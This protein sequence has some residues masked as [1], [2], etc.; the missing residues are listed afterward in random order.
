MPEGFDTDTFHAIQDHGEIEKAINDY[1]TEVKEQIDKLEK[2]ASGLNTQIDE[3]HALEKPLLS[4][5]EH[6]K[7]KVK[8]LTAEVGGEVEKATIEDEVNRLR[9]E[10][11]RLVAES[12]RMTKET[13]GL[14]TSIKSLDDEL[15]QGKKLEGDLMERYTYL[16][17]RKQEMDEFDDMDAEIERLQKEM[18]KRDRDSNVNDKLIEITDDIK[19]DVGS[20]NGKLQSALKDYNEQVDAFMNTVS[21]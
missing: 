2:E 6:L 20:I 5:K 3:K 7:G 4:R 15:E 16:T 12:E 1:V 11:E 18:Q 10:K 19:Q 17:S 21:G 13:N 8:D 14:D 9:D